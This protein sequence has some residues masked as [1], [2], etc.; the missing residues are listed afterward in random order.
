MVEVEVVLRAGRTT[1]LGCDALASE[2]GAGNRHTDEQ[3][4]T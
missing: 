1:L 4:W 3:L 2:R